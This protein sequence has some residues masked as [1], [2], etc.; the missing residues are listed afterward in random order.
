MPLQL[1]VQACEDVICGGS[2]GIDEETK[3]L[4]GTEVSPGLCGQERGAA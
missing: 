2:G 4:C 1:Y 3:T